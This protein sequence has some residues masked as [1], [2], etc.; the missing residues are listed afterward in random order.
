MTEDFR[1]KVFMS[2]AASGSFTMSAKELGI[3][4]PAVSQN[5]SALEKETGVPLFVRTR[6]EAVLTGEGMAFRE[7]ARK[8]LYW[9]SAA[10]D[11]FGKNGKMT[12]SRPIRILSDPAISAYL[13]P[14]ALNIIRSTH[15]ELAFT[16]MDC[17]GNPEDGTSRHDTPDLEITVSPSRDTMDFSGE[18]GLIGIMD[19]AVVSSPSV[20]ALYAASS[21]EEETFRAKPFSTIAGIPAN[22][23]FAVWSGYRK[24]FTPDLMA[25]TAIISDSTEAIKAMTACS[26]SLAGILPA[27]S[28]RKEMTSGDLLQMPVFLPEFTL[29]IHLNPSPEFA[30]RAECRLISD[31]LKN[32]LQK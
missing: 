30:A 26:V 4:Q 21:H 29:D 1:L 24:F 10:A 31:T 15:P 17:M 2:V 7:Y 5:I 27:L 11:M 28:V 9:Y 13:L 6:G 20:K 12:S 16:I 18:E 3:S 19:A 8:I 25:R 14:Q 23:R 22:I 32:N